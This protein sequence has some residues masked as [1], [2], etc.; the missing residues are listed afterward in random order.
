M[1]TKANTFAQLFALE[2]A[3]LRGGVAG[4][5]PGN[6]ATKQSFDAGSVTD[7]PR[8]KAL[9]QDLLG[10]CLSGGGLRSAT[11]GLGVLQALADVR[12]LGRLDYLSTVSGGGYV[13]GFWSRYLVEQSGGAYRPQGEAAAPLPE[14]A[15]FP[16]APSGEPREIR[17]LREFGNFLAPRVGFFQAETWTFVTAAVGAILAGIFPAVAL[18]YLMGGT[19]AGLGA[20]LDR[21]LVPSFVGLTGAMLTGTEWLWRR[22]KK[23]E[24]SER[25]LVVYVLAAISALVVGV[26]SMQLL[27]QPRQ[28]AV[29]ASLLGR[30]NEAGTP[31]P[32]L[33]LAWAVPGL[34]WFA[35]RWL[36]S[37]WELRAGKAAI[38]RIAQRM[39][40]VSLIVSIGFALFQLAAQGPSGWNPSVLWAPTG[41]LAFGSTF[42][43][44]LRQLTSR[45]N[46]D[47]SGF[48]RQRL[49]P[50]LP[51]LL[52]WFAL[53]LGVVSI[54]WVV[55]WVAQHHAG[56]LIPTLA[57]AAGVVVL[58][59]LFFDP[60]EGGLHGAYRG[61]VG[62]TFLGAARASSSGAT[63]EGTRR[64]TQEA[65]NDD[66]PITNLLQRPLHLL[67]CTAN[68]LGGD[69]LANL[70]RG[71]RSAVLSRYGLSIGDAHGGWEDQRVPVEL[72]A[73]VTASA[74]SFNSNMGSLSKE[75]GF[76]AT[77]LMAA[78]N[79]R[80]G[81]WLGHPKNAN[82]TLPR[83]P[84]RLFFRELF[85]LTRSEGTWVHLSDGGHFELL[86]LY[87]LVRRH[88]RYIVVSDAGQDDDWSF[89]YV[90]NAIR[91]IRADFGV[92]VHIDLS[93]L[94]PGPDG[95]S[96]E[97]AA[98]GQIVYGENDFGV[99]VIVKPTLTGD[100]PQD[101]RQYR[102]RHPSFPQQSTGDQFYGE[103]QWESY[104]RLG[105][106]VARSV[107]AIPELAGED[108]AQVHPNRLFA[109]IRS[110]Y[111][112]VPDGFDK[113]FLDLTERCAR[114]EEEVQEQ[115]PE[116][117]LHEVYP[118]LVKVIST[119][120]T[121]AV[122][123]VPP[124]SAHWR[125]SL[126][127]CLMMGQLMEDVWV[128]GRL[129]GYETHP[130]NVGWMNYFQRW[131][132]APTFRMWWP[133]L[134]T[135]FSPNT[136]R[137]VEQRLGVPTCHERLSVRAAGDN[138][139]GFQLDLERLG[140]KIPLDIGGVKLTREK[141]VATWRTSDFRVSPG[142]QGVGLD[143]QALDLLLAALGQQQVR[144]VK[145][146]VDKGKVKRGRRE[147]REAAD[148][149]DIYAKS[150][151][152]MYPGDDG[153]IEAVKKLVEPPQA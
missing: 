34:G 85:G 49:K 73:A 47:G 116:F 31:L 135:I 32:T 76:A 17:H 38:D 25:H 149:L 27:G 15:L 132:T 104:R 143:M 28:G 128:G 78:F 152:R 145:V 24:D 23:A 63:P 57:T 138:S 42:A 124:T 2:M 99:L 36:L 72:G 107:F 67:C 4:G 103:D 70:G 146:R 59:L 9:D 45:P 37:R 117:L 109:A 39:L 98:V 83:L 71:G 79:L 127:I 94:R 21:A 96:R 125:A 97:H 101:I 8:V 82:R 119:N 93:R 12:L 13:G 144:T 55:R 130:L 77:F 60:N 48:M 64:V 40:G 30:W 141:D 110:R 54:T 35:I 90:G 74:A 1:N 111:Y 95:L 81:L 150:G 114:I 3:G 56:L 22:S 142:F 87:E 113:A 126:H 69:S 52:A 10:L 62:R 86:G 133:V 102:S 11:F 44:L 153:G 100:E 46:E 89:G 112:M 88:C 118:E 43:V 147:E 139:W 68:D 7:E 53:L 108:L 41:A 20:L 5:L 51:R 148:H 58:T 131:A 121:E 140:N 91:R 84:G 80:L 106:H 18:L 129:E 137:F 29:V 14:D 136:R 151:F 65:E 120:A 123:A 122:E 16:H 33:P 26:M 92:E 66:L 115:G 75:L 50:H 61:R 19:F 134:R 105:D 6:A